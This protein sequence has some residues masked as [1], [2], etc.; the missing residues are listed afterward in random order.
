MLARLRL[1]PWHEKDFMTLLAGLLF[2]SGRVEGRSSMGELR[3]SNSILMSG[4]TMEL[5]L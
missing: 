3:E 4:S 5:L 1:T 2:S